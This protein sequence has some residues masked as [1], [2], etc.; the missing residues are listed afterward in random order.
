MLASQDPPPPLIFEL[1][2]VQSHLPIVCLCKNLTKHGDGKFCVFVKND[3]K[4]EGGVE[5]TCRWRG[6]IM[7]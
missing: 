6:G 3:Q 2:F 7:A 4:S 1:I 5:L